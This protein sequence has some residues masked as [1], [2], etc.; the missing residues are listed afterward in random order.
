MHVV[1]VCAATSNLFHLAL[2]VLRWNLRPVSYVACSLVYGLT[3]MG[4]SVLLVLLVRLGVLGVLFGQLTGT[5]VAMLLA[6]WLSRH[7]YRPAFDMAILRAMLRFSIPLVPS[8]IAVLFAMYVDRMAIRALMTLSDV[9]LYGIGYR[10]ASIAGLVMVGFQVALTPLVYAHHRDPEMPDQLSTVFRGFVGLA[11]LV[12][13]GIAMFAGE[14]LAVVSTPSYYAASAVVPLLAPAFLLSSM[15]IFAPGLAIARR[16][17]P[18]AG[19]HITSALISTSLNLVLIPVWGITGAATA[20]L[21]GAAAAFAGYMVMS[22]R[23]YPVPHDWARLAVATSTGV[24]CLVVGLSLDPTADWNL[25]GRIAI[26]AVAAGT[27]VWLRVVRLAELRQ[28]FRLSSGANVAKP[29]SD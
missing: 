9:G 6:L 3:V 24:V 12:V 19:I 20:T 14:I 23:H 8:G 22:Q 29:G 28:L 4:S 25:P 1:V 5:M 21:C 7:L 26:L 2:N 17:G 15:Y 11:V 13:L 16:T 27:L 18:I 10:I